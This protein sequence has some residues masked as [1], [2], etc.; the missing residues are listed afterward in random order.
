VND[1]IYIISFRFLACRAVVV[2]SCLTNAPVV[3]F[4]LLTGARRHVTS[5]RSNQ[6][7]G[8]RLLTVATMN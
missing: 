5:N 8:Q 6:K 2:E 7:A 1:E 3:L 4:S